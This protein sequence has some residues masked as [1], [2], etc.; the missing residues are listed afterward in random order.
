MAADKLLGSPWLNARIVTLYFWPGCRSFILISGSVRL[1]D[2][3]WNEMFEMPV[4]NTLYL[5][6]MLPGAGFQ[7]MFAVVDVISNR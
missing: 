1:M 2:L 7:E 3:K 4:M 5:S 6:C